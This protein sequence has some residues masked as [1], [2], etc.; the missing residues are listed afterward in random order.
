MS[1]S[2]SEIK[3]LS[4]FSETSIPIGH[5]VRKPGLKKYPL[6]EMRFESQLF[7]NIRHGSC[8]IHEKEKAIPVPFVE[9]IH[10]TFHNLTY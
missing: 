2:I 10:K 7:P 3:D 9:R 5:S 4:S 6:S 1:K 8:P